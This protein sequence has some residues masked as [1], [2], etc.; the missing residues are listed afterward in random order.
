MC[1]G[2]RR[3]DEKS[4]GLGC[5]GCCCGHKMGIDSV[6]LELWEKTCEKSDGGNKMGE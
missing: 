1:V 4:M 3:L 2:C 6:V 5:W